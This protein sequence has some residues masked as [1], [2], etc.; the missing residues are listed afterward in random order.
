MLK[1]FHYLETERAQLL[2][3]LSRVLVGL[4]L[5][6]TSYFLLVA[7]SLNQLNLIFGNKIVAIVVFL[8]IINLI[9][10]FLYSFVLKGLLRETLNQASIVGK[11]LLS[12]ILLCFAVYFFVGISVDLFFDGWA[13]VV[14]ITIAVIQMLIPDIK[15]IKL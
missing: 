12:Y 15:A 9:F 10:G 4:A 7:V 5:Y 2:T 13:F 1:F 6:L 11:F 3:L 14:G 8:A